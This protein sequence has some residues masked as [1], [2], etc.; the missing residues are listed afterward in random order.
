MSTATTATTIEAAMRLLHEPGEVFEVRILNTARAGTV[1]GYFDDPAAAAQAAA[2]WDGK[3]PGVYVTLNPVNPALMARAKNR[4][5]EWAKTT[6]S[7]PDITRR[8]WILIDIDFRRPTG[9]SATDEEVQAAG[10]TARKI[11]A[12]LEKERG[13][14][15]GAVVHSG[16][17]VHLL[18][19]IDLPA[20]SD[21]VHQ[22]LVA[23]ASRFDDVDA[24]GSALVDTGVHVDTTVGNA[25]RIAKVPGTWACKGDNLPER[26]HRQSKVVEWPDDMQAVDAAALALAAVLAGEGDAREQGAAGTGGNGSGPF[27]VEVWM[28]RNG[29]TVRKHKTD[30]AGDLWELEACPFNP[31]HDKGE[32][33]VSRTPGGA[34]LAGCHH[35]SC[36]WHWGDLHDKYEPGYREKQ[37]EWERGRDAALAKAAH[38]YSDDRSAPHIIPVDEHGE[39][40]VDESAHRR[41]PDCYGLTPLDWPALLRDGVPEVEY[42]REPYLPKLARIWVWGQTGSMKSLWCEHEAA[43]LSREG[44]RVSY[45]AEEN[46]IGEELRRLSKLQPDPAY[47][48]LFHRSGMDLLDEKWVN[49][50]L[51]A[52]K[53]DAIIFLDSWTDLW[54]GDENDNR[55]VQQFDASVLKPL[56]AQ[57]VTPVVIHHL[58]HRYMFSDR[59]GATAGRGASSL[60]QKADVTLE[61]KSAGDDLFTIVYG[62]CRIG[63]LHQPQRSFK[64]EDTDGGR[65]QIAECEALE[66]RTV[67]E[68][69]EKAAQAVLTA[70]RGYLTTNELRVA[71][72]GGRAHQTAAWGVLEDDERVCIGAEKVQAIDGK[73]RDAKV[74]RP[75]A[76]LGARLGLEGLL[77]DDGDASD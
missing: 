49:A 22:V 59:G 34:L 44:V 54:S 71:V 31:E 77:D 15:G 63:G 69:A 58:G 30:G 17:G 70:P 8:R 3:A 43:S 36:T 32:A 16:N 9:I 55:A 52:T 66:D 24:Q 7:N 62:K 65:L 57:G 48:R 47:F 2:K 75:A 50:L 40:L 53:G 37:I 68:L 41:K 27:D 26:P 13:W 39:P 46:P 12:Y 4:L 42:I 74:W 21:L 23:L 35:N 67:A 61:F 25:A 51:A 11:K 38:T 18:Y 72:G 56:Q 1:S 10:R 73:W 29:L 6:T 64:V 19:R 20:D 33:F 5:R 60:G 45:F 76:Y 28:Q 14:P